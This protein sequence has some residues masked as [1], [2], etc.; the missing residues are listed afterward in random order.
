[1]SVDVQ[2]VIQGG[3]LHYKDLTFH[4]QHHGLLDPGVLMVLLHI[5]PLPQGET[6]AEAG[7][8]C[9]RVLELNAMLPPGANAFYALIPATDTLVYRMQFDIDRHPDAANIILACIGLMGEELANAA[10]NMEAE[11]AQLHQ[12]MKTMDEAGAG[13][14]EEDK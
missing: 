11:L 10:A 5:G 12:V 13:L 4:I 9:R 14:K 1:M 6:E 7:L 3:L 8:M 2:H